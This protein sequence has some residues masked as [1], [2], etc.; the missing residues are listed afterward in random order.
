MYC[1]Q[2]YYV[3]L[4]NGDISSNPVTLSRNLRNGSSCSHR[5]KDEKKL[6]Q[7]LNSDLEPG[8]LVQI[9]RLLNLLLNIRLERFYFGEK[10][11]Y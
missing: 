3:L 6:F 11:C 5:R 7:K 2:N 4:P 8:G 1:I 10:N 9:L